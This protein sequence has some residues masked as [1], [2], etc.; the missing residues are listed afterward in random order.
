MVL[1]IIQKIFHLN[2]D[3][4]SVIW[5]YICIRLLINAW[6]LCQLIYKAVFRLTFTTSTG[7]YWHLEQKQYVVLSRW[8]PASVLN[9]LTTSCIKKIKKKKKHKSVCSGEDPGLIPGLWRYP[10]EGN[11]NPVWYSCLEKS[12]G[13]GAWP[14]TVPGVAK[15]WTWL[16]N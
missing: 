1:L 10:G 14:A 3:I 2:L 13:R 16:S 4:I 8:S 12:I 6:I 15:V 11:G 9:A 7:I 5:K